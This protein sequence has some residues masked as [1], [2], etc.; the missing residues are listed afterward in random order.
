MDI[1]FVLFFRVWKK[2]MVFVDFLCESNCVGGW[3]DSVDGKLGSF[4][5]RYGYWVC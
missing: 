2:W 3:F 1:L 5:V 4:Y